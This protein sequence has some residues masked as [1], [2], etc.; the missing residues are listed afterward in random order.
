MRWSPSAGCRPEVGCLQAKLGYFNETQNLLTR[1]FS[2]EYD[3]WFGVVLPA[4]EQPLRG[5]SGR[6]VNHMPTRVWREVGG[7]DEFNVTEDA[8]L[9]VRLARMGTAP[10]SGLGH[11]GRSQFRCRELDPATSRWY[12]GYLQTMIVHLAIP[13]QLRREI[14]TKA[15]L[16]LINM[17]GGIPLANAFN[18]VFWF[19][20]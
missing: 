15:M 18:L 5:A 20:C 3:Q 19:T 7:W 17:T 14:G 10:D 4:V 6:H 13:L 9:G 1:W 16:R 8:D 2:L 11:A 12:K